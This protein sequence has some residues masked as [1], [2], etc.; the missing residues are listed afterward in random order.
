[1]FID[2]H[3]HVFTYKH[4]PDKFLGIKLS[5]SDK[6][7][8][9][10]SDTFSWTIP[11]GDGALE[12]ITSFSKHLSQTVEQ[13]FLDLISYYPED[14]KVCLLLMDM[15][16]I[17]GKIEE[18]YQTQ[19]NEMIELKKKYP[20]KILLF[21]HL[22]PNQ[23][24][25]NQLFEDY[26]TTNIFD[27]VKI[28]PPLNS[29]PT[30][31][32]FDIIWQKCEEFQIPIISHCGKFGVSANNFFNFSKGELAHP[33]YWRDVLE[34]YPKLRLDLAHFGEMDNN[35]QKEII[36]LCKKYDNVY[37][38]TSFI[39]GSSLAIDQLVAQM[40]KSPYFSQ[41]VIYGSDFYLSDLLSFN[42]RDNFLYLK[43][44]LVDD[45]FYNI[46]E[47]NTKKFLKL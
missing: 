17:K 32:Q 2:N 41:K 5:F 14:A 36:S 30:L 33:K 22:D 31:K 1:M 9:W 28:Y 44:Q 35:W 6:I 15:R 7:L 34:R 18:N 46:T 12:N 43:K 13:N 4:V 27:G 37:T 16:Q 26:V 42:V 21:L 45:L 25:M 38:D 8:K 3:A 40:K 23:P 39:I 24:E 47:V 29:N 19:I 11:G 20:D 10:V